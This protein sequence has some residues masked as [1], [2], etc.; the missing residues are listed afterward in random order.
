MTIYTYKTTNHLKGSE[1]KESDARNSGN[2]GRPNVGN[3]S[4]VEWDGKT[5]SAM[6]NDKN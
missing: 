4:S 2:T 3:R 1:S 6:V 5:C